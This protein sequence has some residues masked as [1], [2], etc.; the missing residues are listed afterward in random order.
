MVI[1]ILLISGAKLNK[2]SRTTWH[3][4]LILVKDT[5]F[6]FLTNGRQR[7]SVG[8]AGTLTNKKRRKGEWENWI[9]L[10]LLQTS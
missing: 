4:V 3:I 9:Y 2:Y 10:L 6:F 5:Q 8:I 1:P 7:F